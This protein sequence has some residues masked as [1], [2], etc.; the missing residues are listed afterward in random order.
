[1]TKTCRVLNVMPKNY[2]WSKK[3]QHP[4]LLDKSSR[5]WI[6]PWFCWLHV[7]FYYRSYMRLISNLNSLKPCQIPT[8]TNYMPYMCVWYDVIWCYLV[9]KLTIFQRMCLYMQKYYQDNRITC[10]CPLCLHAYLFTANSLSMPYDC[11][12]QY[13][14]VGLQG[15][16]PCVGL[17][18]KCYLKQSVMM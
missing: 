1:M 16:V 6:Q 8:L 3:H 2:S 10:R 4:I 13:A 5:K 12:L 18:D 11:L 7:S 15:Q 17:L 9:A 14:P